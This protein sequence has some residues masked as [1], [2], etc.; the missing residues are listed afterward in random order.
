MSTLQIISD[1]DW[2]L[3]E[4]I[5]KMETSLNDTVELDE[6]ASL[7]ETRSLSS[8]LGHYVSDD[9]LDE[10]FVNRN[11]LPSITSH[12]DGTPK[13]ENIFALDRYVGRLTQPGGD[14]E[15]RWTPFGLPPS[16]VATGLLQPDVHDGSTAAESNYI[17]ETIRGPHTSRLDNQHKPQGALP[18]FPFFI[19]SFCFKYNHIMPTLVTLLLL[20]SSTN[21]FQITTCDC[22]K[23][24]GV[25]L[26]QF[27]DG[28]CKPATRNSNTKVDYRVM[29]DKKAAFNFP[30]YICGQVITV[31]ELIAMET[32]AVECDIMRQSRRCNESPMMKSENKW[33]FNQ[34]PEDF[35]YWLRTTTVVTFNC[36]LEEVVLSRIDEGDMINTPLGKTNVSHGSL[37]HNHLTLF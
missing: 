35:G 8:E 24:S 30:G 9:A 3:I 4:D 31:P 23:P 12:P 37:S 5:W 17:A 14:S 18:Y 29:T 10:Y 32:T 2:S 19:A 20:L 11:T 33:I 21:V 25:G 36:M 15:R 34:E 16:S 6:T 7:P 26:L 27:S 28:S 13:W 1:E 22:N